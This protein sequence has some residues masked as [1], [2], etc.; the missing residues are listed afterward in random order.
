MKVSSGSA[1]APAFRLESPP[2]V[3]VLL[4]AH[5]H[6]RDCGVPA[7]NSGDQ[8]RAATGMDVAA[9]KR[10]VFRPINNG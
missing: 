6:A 9:I 1:D 8:T 10:L 7:Y 4:H 2:R 5:L 3:D